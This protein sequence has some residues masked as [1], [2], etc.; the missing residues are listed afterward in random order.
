[1]K[2][3]KAVFPVLAAL[4]LLGCGREDAD[5]P[6]AVP[7]P[8][9]TPPASERLAEAAGDYCPYARPAENLD[10]VYAM[11]RD[12][13]AIGNTDTGVIDAVEP[14][15]LRP[16]GERLFMIR[17]GRVSVMRL[18]EGRLTLTES[19]PVGIDWTEN[20]GDTL[21]RG[22]EKTPVALYA[23]DTRLAVISDWVEYR[24]ELKSA[25]SWTFEDLSYTA[26]DIY[27]ISGETVEPVGSFGQSGYFSRGELCGDTLCLISHQELVEADCPPEAG[28]S[29]LPAVYQG[30]GRQ[31]IAP[32][33]MLLLSDSPS[34]DYIMI[35]AC[36]L[37]DASL[38]DSMAV[39]GCC[40]EMAV[41][42]DELQLFFGRELILETDAGTEAAYRLSERLAVSATDVLSVSLRDAAPKDCGMIS[43]RLLGAA[44]SE[45][46]LQLL[47]SESSRFST[48][49]TDDSRGFVN[50]TDGEHTE[51]L[52]C[53]SYDE[54]LHPGG[55][56]CLPIDGENVSSVGNEDGFFWLSVDDN[57]NETYYVDYRSEEWRKLTFPP[58]L[59]PIWFSAW[60]EGQAA[61][62]L[63][64]ADSTQP[65]LAILDFSDDKTEIISSAVL[66]VDFL[67]TE[68]MRSQFALFPDC[69]VIGLPAFDGYSLY[70][71]G[72][73]G[74]LY[75]LMDSFSFGG[76][77][78]VVADG[79][80]LFLYDPYQINVLDAASQRWLSDLYF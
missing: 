35:S 55:E 74:E 7:V 72:E 70:A 67:P 79:G 21:W 32:G 41:Q 77:T 15:V 20:A 64:Q 5:L 54:N 53:R 76:Q 18:A 69:G 58:D 80:L 13:W 33:K 52:L 11:L 56:L 2:L 59:D 43:G 12:A 71:C 62:L 6:S 40:R 16:V 26:A 29:F 23:T 68:E 78:G 4:T 37:S 9:P 75:H 66:G 24:T 57:S 63:K 38:T 60:R 61:A 19:F 30:G 65:L 46:S 3:F 25:G 14:P 47:L 48:V 28:G 31:T 1:M 27:D 22:Y 10:E 8:Q 36:A 17:G 44:S 42:G 39:F 51:R 45:E 73:D 50:V 49:Y 34:A